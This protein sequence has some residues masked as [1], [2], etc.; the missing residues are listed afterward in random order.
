[1]KT[2]AL[3]AALVC[4]VASLTASAAPIPPGGFLYPFDPEP[5][6]EAVGAL[7]IDQIIAP[8]TG[9]DIQGSL[10]SSVYNVDPLNPFGGLTFTYQVFSAG[11]LQPVEMFTVG[12]FGP[13][14]TDVSWDFA[15]PPGPTVPPVYASRNITGDVISF[16]FA[17]FGAIGILPGEGSEILTVR[18]DVPFYAP[19]IASV[20]N[21][22]SAEVQS[23]A[24]GAVPEPASMALIGLFAG[25]VCFV[26]SFF[27]C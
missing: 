17:L 4:A 23:F 25:G 8:Y 18:T 10:V 16:D 27:I 26:R 13:F 1:M 21:S 3:I 6:P 24:P 15:G 9:A 11:S 5:G 19:T 2:K 14:L 20:I 22:G 12:N 7:L